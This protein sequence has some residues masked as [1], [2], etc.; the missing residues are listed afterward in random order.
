M[1]EC[2]SDRI[3][4]GTGLGLEYAKQAQP[5]LLDTVLDALCHPCARGRFLRPCLQVVVVSQGAPLRQGL[6][7]A[8]ALAVALIMKPD[9]NRSKVILA[10]KKAIEATFDDGRWREL[11]YLTD[12]VE[13][14]EGHPR[15]LRSLSWGDDDYG[16]CILQVLPRILGTNPENLRSVE[17]F[18]G[19]EAWLRTN[20][21]DLYEQLYGG[22]P[23]ALDEL[24]SVHGVHNVLELNQQIARIRRSIPDDPALAVGSAK[25]LLETVL[26]TIL[27]ER[28][29]TSV[30]GDIPELLKEVQK[31]TGLDPRSIV[32]GSEWETLRRTLSNLAQ[33]IVGVDEVR[34]LAGTG[35]GRTKTPPLDAVHARLVVNSAATIATYL[36]EMHERTKRA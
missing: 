12:T 28:G 25:D 34:N 20:E 1:E 21:P 24:E 16:T 36:L 19:L 27:E 2:E 33:V 30:R 31:L 6:S 14:V 23:T 8:T 32:R 5:S 18:V 29:I 26:K 11:A 10:F 4:T 13:L 22:L 35:H 15:L 9:A 3:R 17:E 7:Q